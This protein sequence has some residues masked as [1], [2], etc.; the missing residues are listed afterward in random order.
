MG[1]GGRTD[2]GEEQAHTSSRYRFKSERM[3]GAGGRCVPAESAVPVDR[4]AE[5]GGGGRSTKGDGVY[6]IKH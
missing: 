4:N 6:E 2:R 3:S 5:S 1:Q